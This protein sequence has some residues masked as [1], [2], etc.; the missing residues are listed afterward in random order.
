M[1]LFSTLL[2]AG[3][4]RSGS[5]TSARMAQANVREQMRFQERMRNTG[6]QAAARDLKAAGLNRILALGSPAPSPGGAAAAVPDLGSSMAAGA[7]AATS[8]KMAAAQTKLISAQAAKVAA[9][10]RT[11]DVAADFAEETRGRA[12]G[13]IGNVDRLFDRGLYSDI[14]NELRYQAVS[15]AKRFAHTAKM[16]RNRIDELKRVDQDK[17]ERVLKRI[18]EIREQ[19]ENKRASGRSGQMRRRH[20]VN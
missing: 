17:I 7:N 16:L 9:E 2:G 20:S 3:L 1:G 15:G 4:A 18:G 11:A 12:A 10:T 6:Y 13:A 5:L 19:E 14:G 8:A